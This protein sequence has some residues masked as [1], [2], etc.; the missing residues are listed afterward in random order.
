MWIAIP[1]LAWL[2]FIAFN[3]PGAKARYLLIDL[4]ENQA[5]RNTGKQYRKN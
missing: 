1:L 2:V 4:K 5:Q 3:P